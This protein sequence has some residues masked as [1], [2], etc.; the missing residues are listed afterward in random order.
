M[1]RLFALHRSQSPSALLL[2]LVGRSEPAFA[3]LP[4]IHPN[5][6]FSRHFAQRVAEVWEWVQECREQAK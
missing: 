4:T 3:G 6:V 2:R 5:S 1:D